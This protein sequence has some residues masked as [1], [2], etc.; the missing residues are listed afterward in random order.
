[1]KSESVDLALVA[2]D[3]YHTEL[4]PHYEG[5][6]TQLVGR[7]ATGQATLEGLRQQEVESRANYDLIRGFTAT[8][9]TGR[10]TERA[11]IVDNP[12]H[13]RQV[14]ANMLW[15]L[16]PGSYDPVD[17]QYG[18]HVPYYIVGRRRATPDG[19]NVKGSPATDLLLSSA[20][21]G[22]DPDVLRIV[23]VRDAELAI[24]L[25]TVQDA[26]FR[27]F[28]A[29]EIA[30][31]F[32]GESGMLR[33]THDTGM[34]TVLAHDSPLREISRPKKIAGKVATSGLAVRTNGYFD[35]RIDDTELASFDV[36]TSL[37]RLATAFDKKDELATLLAAYKQRLAESDG[38]TPNA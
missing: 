7:L 35:R 3:V 4:S 18:H 21:H 9:P 37:N 23:T 5:L 27:D 31:M 17:P 29:D 14:Q 22:T 30:R 28:T 34:R 26:C 8:L 12:H 36:F 32:E 1:M 2:L 24:A 11:V 6:R 38:E 15:L 16:E 10:D 33:V 19:N 13:A 25:Q 20:A